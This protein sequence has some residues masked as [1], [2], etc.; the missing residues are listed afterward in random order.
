M[1]KHIKK[2]IRILGGQSRLAKALGKT[3]PFVSLMLNEQKPVPAGL[4]MRIEAV[5]EGQVTAVQILPNVFKPVV[6]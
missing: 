6:L 2:A 5:T 4:C 1:N 3:Q